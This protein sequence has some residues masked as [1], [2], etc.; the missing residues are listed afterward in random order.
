MLISGE[1]MNCL[2][3]NFALLDFFKD[4]WIEFGTFALLLRK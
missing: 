2:I 1:W 4:G 3:D